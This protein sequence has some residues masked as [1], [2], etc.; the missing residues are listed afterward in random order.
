ML[1]RDASDLLAGAVL[2]I[3]CCAMYLGLTSIWSNL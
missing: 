3:F 2:I 1:Q